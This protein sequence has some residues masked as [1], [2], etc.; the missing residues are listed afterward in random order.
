MWVE[1]IPVASSVLTPESLN[2]LSVSAVTGIGLIIAA[3]ATGTVVAK[4]LDIALTKVKK[5]KG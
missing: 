1:M 4:G 3:T 2:K 5:P